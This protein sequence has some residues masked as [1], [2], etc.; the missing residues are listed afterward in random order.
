MNCIKCN[1][2]ESQH[3]EGFT[4]HGDNDE[5][6]CPKFRGEQPVYTLAVWLCERTDRWCASGQPGRLNAS[7][8]MDLRQHRATHRTA[9]PH[10][11]RP[12]E[13]LQRRLPRR[14]LS[15]LRTPMAKTPKDRTPQIIELAGHLNIPQGDLTRSE[16]AL[17]LLNELQRRLDADEPMPPA[18]EGHPLQ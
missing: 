7:L 17:A 9:E 3:P 14:L 12:P 1:H 8:A 10:V 13:A 4:C 11:W 2:P 5:C 18:Y 16:W 6:L 15:L